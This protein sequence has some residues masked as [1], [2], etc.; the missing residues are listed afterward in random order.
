MSGSA[1]T[2]YDRAGN[3]GFPPKL[4]VITGRDRKICSGTAGRIEKEI[5][6]AGGRAFYAEPDE[7][8][9][10]LYRVTA[11]AD[12]DIAGTIEAAANILN[13]AG[14]IFI[15]PAHDID[16]AG[17]ARLRQRKGPFGAVI[18]DTGS[19]RDNEEDDAKLDEA[20]N[21][22]KAVFKKLNDMLEYYL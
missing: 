10:M 15:T 2:P 4:I 5:I 6:S 19:G 14:V 8:G 18:V 21:Q 12:P 7:A 13:E 3:S 20:V 17:I 16:E 9:R 11:G 1:Y 22:I